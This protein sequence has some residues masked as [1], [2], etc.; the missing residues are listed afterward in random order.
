MS[1]SPAPLLEVENLGKTYAIPVLENVSLRLD[2]G[3]VLALAGENGAGKSTLS[4]II[5]GVIGFS[6]YFSSFNKYGSCSRIIASNRTN[7]TIN[8]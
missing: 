4:K 3:Q 1:M 5:S 7:F 6:N 2:A 8:Q